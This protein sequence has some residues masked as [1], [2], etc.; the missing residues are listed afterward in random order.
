MKSMLNVKMDREVKEGVQ[1][2]AREVGMPVSTIINAYLRQILR[3]RTLTISVPP[4]MTPYLERTIATAR[5]DYKK[6]KN[7]SP[8]LSTPEDVS[9][10]FRAL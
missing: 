5:R 6:K 1:E 2:F 9:R 4:T 10:Y 7:L 3:T 8:I